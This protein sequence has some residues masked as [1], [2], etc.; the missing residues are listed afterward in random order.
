MDYSKL[1]DLNPWWDNKDLINQDIHLIKLETQKIKWDYKIIENLK[2][3]IY[4]LRGPRQIGKTTWIK[5]KI[6][7]L[8]KKSNPKNIFFYSCDDIRNFEELIE[9]ITLFLEITN[10]EEKKYIFLDEIPY[11]KDWQRALK[12]LY[13]SGK[14][15]RCSVVLSGSHSID[16]K[17]SIEQLPG[18]GDEGKRHFL[19]MP[20]T[21]NQYLEAIGKSI[22]LTNNLEKD[23]ALLKINSRMLTT[24]YRNYLL[25]GGFLKI[26]N[27][28]F[29][30]KEISD[31]SYDVY[32]KWIIGDLAKWELKEQFSKQ[33]VK[34]IIES[35]TSELSWSSIKSG[36]DIES[37]HT[38]S[39]YVNAIEEMFVFNIL[40]KMDFNKKTPD[41]P[42][43]KKVYFSDPFIFSACYKWISSIENNFQTYQKYLD[44]NIDKISEGVLL[45]HIINIIY[46]KVKSNVY[47]YKDMVYYWKN[48]SKTKEIDFV[49]K[50]IAFEVKY[51]EKIKSTDYK[52]LKEFKKAFLVTKKT[53]DKRT[54]PIYAFLILLEKYPKD[55]LFS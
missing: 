18:R 31:P 9:L 32:L 52:E 55:F 50:N 8:L 35:Y 30:K 34:K 23:I 20:L 40:Y 7:S 3:G 49:Y 39:K 22:K 5:L 29:T 28:F 44:K 38:I 25:T 54:Y 37:H 36:T 1:K 14:L 41:F 13:D 26:I 16:I 33:I 11:V 42:K 19:I 27:E 43:S 46:Q 45:N 6:K 48:K 21:F 47:D 10:P 2:E 4:S 53:F 12:H 51:K 15:S 24:E 17:R